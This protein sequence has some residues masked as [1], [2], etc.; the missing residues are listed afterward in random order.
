M[1]S[2]TTTPAAFALAR[3]ANCTNIVVPHRSQLRERSYVIEESGRTTGRNCPLQ[4]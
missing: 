3:P 1:S 2:T 4:V